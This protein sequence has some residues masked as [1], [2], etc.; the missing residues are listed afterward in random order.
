M[1]KWA[2]LVPSVSKGAFGRL[3]PLCVLLV[4]CGLVA[5]CPS[6]TDINA[7]SEDGI[8]AFDCAVTSSNWKIQEWL[9][10]AG[11]RPSGKDLPKS[12][13]QAPINE[14]HPPKWVPGSA[15]SSQGG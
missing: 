13:Q 8:T 5:C 4:V 11:G 7:L 12:R 10:N 6:L 2:D 9:K 1:W 15:A 3:R 14:R